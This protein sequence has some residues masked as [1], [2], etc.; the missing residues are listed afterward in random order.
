MFAAR[1]GASRGDDTHACGHTHT[2]LPWR[3][4][5]GG[6]RGCADATAKVVYGHKFE[7]ER[8]HKGIKPLKSMR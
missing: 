7:K 2:A 5:T 1:R 3:G 6:V 8:W 4:R